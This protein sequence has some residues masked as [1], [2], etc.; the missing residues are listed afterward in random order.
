MP[1]MSRIEAAFCTSAPWRFAARRL[2]LPW[3]LMGE[4]LAG[5]VL[6][7]GSGSG[8]MAA[9]I[10]ESFPNTSITATDLDPGMLGRAETTLSP[11]GS[12]ATV[13]AADATQLEF[14][15]ETFDAVV[16]FMMLHH[17]GDWERA[18]AEAARVV[19]PGGLVLIADFVEFPG[20]R[21]AEEALGNPG[22]RPIPWKSLEPEAETLPLEGVHIR[23][24]AGAFFR[25]RALRR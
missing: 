18:L 2:I 20:L 3:A 1:A 13:T 11:Y 21:R 25:M 9:E 23:R 4:E 15:R 7:V 6:E 22:V 12:R 5:S 14:P 19:K 8:A 24:S 16:S 17:V 10:L